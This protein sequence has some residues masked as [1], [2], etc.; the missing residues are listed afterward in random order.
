LEENGGV[1][2]ACDILLAS[3]LILAACSRQPTER[4]PVDNQIQDV[5]PPPDASLSTAA[6]PQARAAAPAF[7]GVLPEAFPKDAPPYV[8]STL[9]DFGE[10]WVEFQTPDAPSVVRG[11]YPALL[12]NRGWSAS[13]DAFVKAGRSLKVSY[14]DARPGTTIRVA[15]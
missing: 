14:A 7:S 10:G 2:R 3:L 1:R 4:P 9:V 5:A 12:R 15:Y 6:D 11:R 13:G 8:P